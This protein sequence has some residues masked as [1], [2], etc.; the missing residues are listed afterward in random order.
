MDY[1]LKVLIDANVFIDYIQKRP[2]GFTGAFSIFALSARE[3]IRLLVTDLTIA[4]M[5]YS[6]R[7]DI[8]AAEFYETIKG[9]R[10]LFVI[11]PIGEK[12]VDQALAVEARDF[13][14]ALQYFAAE[15]A[16]VDCIVTRNTKDFVFGNTVEVL[17]P[18]DFLTKVFCRSTVVI[19]RHNNKH[20]EYN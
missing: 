14:D 9:L 8:P 11:I 10:E 18:H 2:I 7:K 4:N 20:D 15:Q 6:L 3:V 5:K 13:E 1:N 12:C 19:E 17:E 16:G